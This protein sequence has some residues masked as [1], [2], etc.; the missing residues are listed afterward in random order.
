MSVSTVTATEWGVSF[1]CPSPLFSTGSARDA[2]LV[3]IAAGTSVTLN[4]HRCD[5]D[6][7]NA[8]GGHG[9]VISHPEYN[10]LKFA[11][12]EA[13]HDFALSVGLLKVYVRKF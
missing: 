10:G 1:T 13:A 4:V 7:V 3:E 8:W 2:Q 12:S 11:T 6:A 5:E 9:V